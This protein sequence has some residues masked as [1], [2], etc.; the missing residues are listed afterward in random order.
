MYQHLKKQII[1]FIMA[2]LLILVISTISFFADETLSFI[3]SSSL[4]V[5]IGI[6]MSLTGLLLFA[7]EGILND[8]KFHMLQ[9]N[10]A[11]AVLFF[12]IAEI[13]GISVEVLGIAASYQIAIGLVQLIGV[14]LWVEGVV[15]YLYATNSVLEFSDKK[16]IMPLILILSAIP[17]IVVQ[18]FILLSSAMLWSHLIV[19]I[20]LEIGLTIVVISN[21]IILY[22]FR[23][24]F[25]SLPLLLSIIG[26]LALLARTIIWSSIFPSYATPAMQIMAAIAY[27]LIGFSIFLIGKGERLIEAL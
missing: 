10:L 3:L 4:V 20:L 22:H 12:S 14:L 25:F 16:L 21:L 11:I 6:L 27:W 1:P 9:T 15:F 24:G 2:G 19:T 17:Y 23:K 18:V 8:D 13:L 7:R 26:T 5:A